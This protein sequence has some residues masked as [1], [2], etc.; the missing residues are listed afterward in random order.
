MLSFFPPWFPISRFLS[1][2]TSTRL[3]PLSIRLALPLYWTN[4][5][6]LMKTT[7]NPFSGT[8]VSTGTNGYGRYPS[9]WQIC[10]GWF[11]D[12]SH[13][14]P[15]SSCR[16]K[17]PGTYF[18]FHPHNL[19][20]QPSYFPVPLWKR[21]YVLWLALVD[22]SRMKERLLTCTY[23]LNQSKNRSIQ[24]PH[25]LPSSVSHVLFFLKLK[26]IN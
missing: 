7:W 23:K 19:T 5:S 15:G 21:R 2:Y 1:S 6:A 14:F 16:L 25:R 10:P 8:I 11:P 3:L 20:R 13:T 12:V 17:P 18:L 9:V 22:V 26:R 4:R 24:S